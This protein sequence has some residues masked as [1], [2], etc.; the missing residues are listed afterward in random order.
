MIQIVL[1]SYFAQKKV[2]CTHTYTYFDIYEIKN[3]EE[4]AF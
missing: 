1:D 3:I 2:V 4:E